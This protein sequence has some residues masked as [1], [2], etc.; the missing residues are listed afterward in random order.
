LENTMA[1]QSS[2][3]MHQPS[4]SG[5][6]KWMAAPLREHRRAW[7]GM[8]LLYFGTVAL[9]ML[10][11]LVNPAMQQSLL[12]SAGQA[13]S[14][15][16]TLGPLVQAYTEGRLGMAI[17]LTFLVNL[18]LGSFLVLSLPS[19]VIPFAGILMGLLRAW[20]WGVLFSPFGTEMQ[21]G[22]LPHALTVLLEG[23]AYV[24]AMLGVWLWWWP[25]LRTPGRRW[26][27]WR[28]GLALQGRIYSVVAL[29]LAIAAIYEALEVILLLPRLLA[30]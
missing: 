15:T 17:L 3:G 28:D 13:F 6:L 25:V 7:L 22:L 2:I 18:V 8:N 24:V 23:E 19:L 12:Q 9:G 29:L 21:A 14:P 20:L 10:A 4:T 11:V 16:G 1:A 5:I 27:L 30:R 26:Q